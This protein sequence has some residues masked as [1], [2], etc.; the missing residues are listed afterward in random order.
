MTEDLPSSNAI[1]DARIIPGIITRRVYAHVHFLFGLLEVLM[2]GVLSLSLVSLSLLLVLL[3][4]LSPLHSH[5]LLRGADDQKKPMSLPN[6]LV[7]VN[8]AV[9]FCVE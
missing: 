5:L 1:D 9:N 4:M 3:R 7:I 8:S 6:W 2:V